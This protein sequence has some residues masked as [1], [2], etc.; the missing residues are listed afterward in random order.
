LITGAAAALGVGLGL[1]KAFTEIDGLAKTSD[2]LGLTTEALAGLR[3]AAQLTGV[4]TGT[5]DMAL[6]RMTRRVSEAA[7][8]TGEAK[9][10]LAE[11]NIDAKTLTK[12]APDAQFRRIALAFGSVAGES[13]RVRLAMKLFDSEGVALV[14]TLALG[15]DGLRASADEAKRFGIALSRIDASQ[16][17]AANDAI[18]KMQSSISGVFS[19][20]AVKVAPFIELAAGKFADFLSDNNAIKAI[21]D[22][23]FDGI[24][25]IVKTVGNVIYD[26][27]TQFQRMSVTILDVAA[28]MAAYAGNGSAEQTFK[29]QAKSLNTSANRRDLVRSYGLTFGDNIARYLKMAKLNS[30]NAATTASAGI[31]T[32]RASD[33]RVQMY[34]DKIQD[35]ILTALPRIGSILAPFA[36]AFVGTA[37]ASSDKS[38]NAV[39]GTFGTEALGR[40]LGDNTT[41][42]RMLEVAIA[43]L[44]EQKRLNAAMRGGAP[45]TF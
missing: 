42:K 13:N 16:V 24:I 28:T 41:E 30:L 36:S 35:G 23:A 5:L 27:I 11:L 44:A 31:D 21:I 9:N 43:Q 7:R 12:L 14:N 2:K 8:G 39:R 3:H 40:I 6:Q 20:L 26:L 32:R 18:T 10:A 34:A 15:E 1:K 38:K 45:I 37:G 22:G 19:R 25:S 4:S 17:E 29:D 33:N